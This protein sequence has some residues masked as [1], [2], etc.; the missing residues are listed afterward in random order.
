MALAG[1]VSLAILHE[2]LVASP[3]LAPAAEPVR[4]V[5]G[6]RAVEPGRLLAEAV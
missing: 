5:V 6:D 2:R 3:A 1:A 4:L